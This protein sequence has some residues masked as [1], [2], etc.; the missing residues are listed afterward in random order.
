MGDG[1]DTRG[2][3]R[4]GYRPELDGLRAL[5]VIGVLVSH[6]NPRVLPLGGTIGVET[7]FVLSGFLITALLLDER[8]D[9]GR[10]DLGAFWRRRA[11][12]LLPALGVLLL[13]C[14]AVSVVSG[15]QGTLVGA[16]ASAIYVGNYVLAAG[17]DLGVLGHLWTLAVEEQFYL[18][19]PLVFVWAYRRGGTLFVARATAVVLVAG[20][21]WRWWLVESGAEGLHYRTD[22][23]AWGMLAGCLAAVLIHRGWR[24]TTRWVP[25]V[26]VGGLVVLAMMPVSD[27]YL[28]ALPAGTIYAVA[29]CAA[30]CTGVPSRWLAARPLVGVGRLSYALY[31]WHLPLYRWLYGTEPMGLVEASVV[32][33][34]SL[35]CAA[36]SMRWVEQ[37]ARRWVRSPSSA[38]T[39]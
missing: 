37:P 20:L 25:V 5:A 26:G 7:F 16:G 23:R 12:R 30:T 9:T 34:L 8:S 29:V 15:D 35:G 11:V 2:M 39:T 38:R 3:W 36:A 31:L 19:W 1:A 13:V 24:V 32:I 28:R 33:G 10:V 4:L 17:H 27:V 14:V 6:A 18:L 22:S 21:L